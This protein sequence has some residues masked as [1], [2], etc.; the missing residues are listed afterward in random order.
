MNK[1]T[2]IIESVKKIKRQQRER[3]GDSSSFAWHVA[4]AQV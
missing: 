4:R 1:N 2:R 3:G